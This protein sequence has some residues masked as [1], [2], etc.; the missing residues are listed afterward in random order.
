MQA[1][2]RASTIIAARQTPALPAQIAENASDRID[3]RL[4]LAMNQTIGATSALSHELPAELRAATQ[5]DRPTSVVVSAAQE[6]SHPASRSVRSSQR[7][8]HSSFARLPAETPL[9]KAPSLKR[10]ES[11]AAS[12]VPSLPRAPT[13]PEVAAAQDISHEVSLPRSST[14]QLHNTSELATIA[15]LAS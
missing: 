2:D 7:T 9:R 10:E 12:L 1:S 14:L 15:G 4:Q 13:P 5:L 8:K 6:E 11:K 3:S